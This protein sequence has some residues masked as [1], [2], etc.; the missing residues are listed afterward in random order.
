MRGLA[1]A[2]SD[3]ARAL[4]AV[5]MKAY[6]PFAA[7]P[8]LVLSPDVCLV[9]VVS[10]DLRIL[11]FSGQTL[12]TAPPSS[13]TLARPCS[14]TAVTTLAGDVDARVLD[15]HQL[16]RLADLELHHAM[17]RGGAALR[18]GALL[19]VGQEQRANTATSERKS[20]CTWSS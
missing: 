14:G 4:S 6:S 13:V 9:G 7:G 3:M 10:E 11:R 5:L 17:R 1:R 16:H 12:R 15:A 2:G 20:D 8:L 18:R 19:A